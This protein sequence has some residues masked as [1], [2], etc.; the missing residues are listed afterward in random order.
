MQQTRS[1][2]IVPGPFH[3]PKSGKRI[4]AHFMIRGTNRGA[5]TAAIAECRDML[6]VISRGAEKFPAFHLRNP[7]IFGDSIQGRAF[8]LLDPESATLDR[9]PASKRG[10]SRA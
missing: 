4:L 10:G 8:V 2:E 3:L 9:D 7:W 1:P 5:E 6:E